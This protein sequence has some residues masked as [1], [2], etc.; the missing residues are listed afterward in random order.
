MVEAEEF[1]AGGTG[2]GGPLGLAG[3]DGGPGTPGLHRI[4]LKIALAKRF[5]CGILTLG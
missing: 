1:A 3:E 5:S 2:I 4:L